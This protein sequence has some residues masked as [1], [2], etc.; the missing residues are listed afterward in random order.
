MTTKQKLGTI[1]QLPFSTSEE[2]AIFRDELH[3]VGF[4]K[5]KNENEYFTRA[6]E[7]KWYLEW[8]SSNSNIDPIT[9]T[10]TISFDIQ[11]ILN[12]T[13]ELG[14]RCKKYFLRI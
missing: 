7:D 12:E 5:D 2:V 11:K 9:N 10:I 4:F 6:I 14:F 1:T 8:V 3:A 13:E